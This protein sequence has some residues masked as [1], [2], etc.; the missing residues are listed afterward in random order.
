MSSL[1]KHNAIDIIKKYL[2]KATSVYAVDYRDNLS[3]SQDRINA[4]L[5]NKSWEALDEITMDWDTSDGIKYYT[6]DLR[7]ELK[8]N[9]PDDDVDLFIVENEEDI[10]DII[11]SR[12]DSNI[13]KSLSNNTNDI[14][15]FATVPIN[16][17][18]L[19]DSCFD[20][21]KTIKKKIRAIKKAIGIKAGNIK[22]DERIGLMIIQASYGGDLR[23]YFT[24]DAYNTIKYSIDKNAIYFKGDCCIAIV[25]SANGSGDHCFVG[26][27]NVKISTSNIFV[28]KVV[29]YSYTYDV[30]GMSSDWCEDT[31]YSFVNTR[32][33]LAI[34][35]KNRIHMEQ[36]N[37]Y[38]RIFKQ[39]KCSFGDMNITRHREVYYIN[40]YPCG[41][42]CPHCGT[43]WID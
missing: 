14:V 18:L 29:K 13:L 22:Y 40:N 11:H 19:G 17:E 21:P 23:I 3:D 37:E 39:G 34:E 33:K 42:K 12:D 32:G 27:A 36:Q 5:R 25:N 7:L 15:F 38:D 4:C 1:D 35:E 6:D 28:D 30:C 9:F 24:G 10:A 8:S 43:F 16:E 26:D 2:P 20:E 41:N 31:D